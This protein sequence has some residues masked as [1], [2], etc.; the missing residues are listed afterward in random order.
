MVI[1][2]YFSE[3]SYIVYFHLDRPVIQGS[4]LIDIPNAREIAAYCEIEKDEVLLSEFII[5]EI[6]DLHFK[7]WLD[8]R[9]FLQIY[10]CSHPFLIPNTGK[11]MK[12]SILNTLG[13]V[14][15]LKI[16]LLKN[17]RL[18]F[19]KRVNRFIIALV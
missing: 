18:K 3:Y 11:G 9:I 8:I 14:K 7:I 17:F 16:M 13:N 15:L 10:V 1:L 5:S 19:L 6:F 12:F 4:H 2:F